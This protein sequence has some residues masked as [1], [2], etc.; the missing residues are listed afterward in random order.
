MPTFS[1][2]ESVS[3]VLALRRVIID[4]VRVHTVI[5][6]AMVCIACGT[7]SPSGW[8]A[9]QGSGGADG[10]ADGETPGNTGGLGGPL[11]GG[12]A[13]TLVRGDA[14][15]GHPGTASSVSIDECPGTL[16]AATASALAA[17]G[18]VDPKMRWLYP[19]DRTVFPGGIPAPVLQ[20]D[21]QAGGVD[22]VYLHLQSKL[23]EY[24][25]CFGPANPAQL[26]VPQKPWVQAWLQSGGAPDP[27]TVELTTIA[28][29]KVSGPIRETWIFALGSLKGVV[30]YNTYTSQI[31]GNN[32]AVMRIAPGATTPTALIALAG[33]APVGPCVS[34]HSVSANGQTLVAQRHFY[35]F[36]GGSGLVDSE[37]YDLSPGSTLNTNAPLAKI[38]NDDWGLSAMYPDGSRLLTNGQPNQTGPPFPGAAGNNPGM[39]GP[40]ASK[41]YD[42]RTGA[43]IPFAGLSAKYAMMPMFSPN[44][45]KVVF[46]DSDHGGGHSLVVMDF[47]RATNT[48]SN[49]VT[50]FQDP[51]LYPGWPFMTPDSRQV[52]F[53]A[54]DGN[55]F[56]S[57]HDPPNQHVAKSDLYVVSTA[58]GPARALD[59][60]NGYDHGQSYLPYPGRDEH[61]NFYPTVSPVASGAYFWVYFTSRRNYGNTLVLD[62]T[63]TKSMKIWVSA[64]E[65]GETGQTTSHPAF[66]LP[67]QELVSGNIR[68]FA[69]LEPCKANGVSCSSGID[70]CGGSCQSA[71]CGKPTG[72]SR[73]D[74]KCSTA[75]DCCDPSLSCINGYCATTLR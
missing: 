28:A 30:Y 24:K 35:L 48:F 46:N 20:W 73:L 47:D 6:A 70:C 57:T 17:G 63:N 23:F 8:G 2:F 61:L 19:Y 38:T 55:N 7:G 45:A 25:G 62:P 49:P 60:A 58:G 5:L 18:T 56:A 54:G 3:T 50:I 14:G 72:C 37:S 75:A 68:A 59:G 36:G 15:A 34:C 22:G 41:M 74:E 65:I 11:L 16:A 52:V 64:L 9:N 43:A 26:P 29:G 67:G 71:V 13:G 27:L 10:G 4:G 66:Y 69:T 1:A 40:A 39:V 44:G 21:P 42:P 51:S 31:A 32:G 33:S 53:V 12:D